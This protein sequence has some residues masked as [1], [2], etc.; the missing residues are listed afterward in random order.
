MKRDWNKI[1]SECMTELY[2]NSEPK[3]DFNQLVKFSKENDLKDENGRYVMFFSRYKIEQ[4]KFD[5]I[6]NSV[7][8]KYRIKEPYLTGFRAEIYLGASPNTK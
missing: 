5:S 4:A 6:F 3:A 1:Y 8:K 7:V 2:A